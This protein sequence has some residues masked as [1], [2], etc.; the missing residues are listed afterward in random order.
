MATHLCHKN[1]C[2]NLKKDS[3]NKYRIRTCRRTT[4]WDKKNTSAHQTTAVF[5]RGYP[6][7]RRNHYISHYPVSTKELSHVPGGLSQNRKSTSL[8]H[9]KKKWQCCWRYG[10]YLITHSAL[11]KAAFPNK[12]TG[13][14]LTANQK[15]GANFIGE[16]LLAL[17]LIKP[18]VNITRLE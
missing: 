7:K 1:I 5:Q 14:D 10:E 6:W 18:V 12:K 2:S 13:R 15:A 17:L 3:R 16:H 4:M 8:F 11:F 9:D